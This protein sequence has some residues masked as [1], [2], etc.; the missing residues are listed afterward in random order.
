MMRWTSAWILARVKTARG[1]ICTSLVRSLSETLELPSNT[2]WLTM[3]FSVTRMVR[4]PVA[5]SKL[6]LTSENRPVVVSAFSAWSVSA[7][8]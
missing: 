7:G 4:V 6:V 8:V 2:T 1:L 3:G 5:P